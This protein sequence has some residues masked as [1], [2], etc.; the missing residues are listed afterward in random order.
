MDTVQQPSDGTCA[1]LDC[2]AVDELSIAP[3]FPLPTGEAAKRLGLTLIERGYEALLYRA[4]WNSE[5]RKFD[6]KPVGGGADHATR[7]AAELLRRF[8]R[9][10]DAAIGVRRGHGVAIVDD[11][12]YKLAD[13]PARTRKAR[14]ALAAHELVY[15]VPNF[16]TASGGRHW[17]FS[18]LNLCGRKCVVPGFELL[19]NNGFIA[20]A[21]ELPPI[22]ELQPLPEKL[23]AICTESPPPISTFS[24]ASGLATIEGGRNLFLTSEAGKLQRIGLDASALRAALHELNRTHC[25]PPLHAEEVDTISRSILRY[26]PHP[27]AAPPASIGAFTPIPDHAFVN[28]PP[29][30]W[31]IKGVLPKAGLAIVYGQSGSGKSF[32]VLDMAAAI[33]TG[34]LWHGRKTNRARAVFVLAEGA[35]G[36]QNRLKAHAADHGRLPG[37]SIIDRAPHLLDSAQ[38]QQLSD[39]IL[40]AGG[41]DIIVVDTLMASCPGADENAAKDMGRVIDYCKQIGTTCKATVILVHHSGKDESRGARGWSGLRA[42][43]DAEIEVTRVGVYHTAR[44]SKLKDGEDGAEFTFKLRPIVVGMDPDG[45]PVRSCIVEPVTDAVQAVRRK[46]P[47]EGTLPHKLLNVIRTSEPETDGWIPMRPFIDIVTKQLPTSGSRDTRPQKIARALESLALSGHIS[48][49]GERCQL[50]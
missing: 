41:T 1:T 34:S 16:A 26:P 19:E 18:R 31:H 20:V 7:S 11:D 50:T 44:V 47:R 42:A 43:V 46:E 17:Y 38:C 3:A 9:Y 36:F 40:Q 49:E 22:T 32:L 12:G 30:E 33:A 48:V 5:K 4:T 37:I 15:G 28:R 13:T 24:V 14:G 29:L 27:Q 23:I 21:G 6:K 10:P 8:Q 45:E 39:E 2:I 35:G 25:Q